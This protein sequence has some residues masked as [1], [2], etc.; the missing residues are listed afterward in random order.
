MTCDEKVHIDMLVSDAEDQPWNFSQKFDYIHARAMLS[1][2]RSPSWVIH[3]AFGALSPGGYLELQDPQMPITCID[4][5]M[6]GTALEHWNTVVSQAA[7]KLGRAVTNSKNYGRYMEEA[8]FV[9][10]VEKHFFWQLNS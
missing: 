2:F 4:S 6:S 5:T 7:E 1:C 9:D 8:G 3:Q 10:I